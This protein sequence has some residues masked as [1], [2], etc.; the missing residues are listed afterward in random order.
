MND[1][2]QFPLKLNLN[3]SVRRRQ[4]RLSH[5]DNRIMLSTLLAIVNFCPQFKQVVDSL[6][7]NIKARFFFIPT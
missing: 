6:V 4:E 2:I 7:A 3:T 1:V 5:H